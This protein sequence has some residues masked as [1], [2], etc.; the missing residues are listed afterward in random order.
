MQLHILSLWTMY[1]L[2]LGKVGITT[3]YGVELADSNTQS[4]LMNQQ[5]PGLWLCLLPPPTDTQQPKS[6]M[7]IIQ[8]WALNSSNQLII[9]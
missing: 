2:E 7:L 6:T 4:S 9:Q 1:T 3:H 8:E 5:Q